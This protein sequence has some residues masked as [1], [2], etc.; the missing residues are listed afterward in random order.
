MATLKKSFVSIEPEVGD[1]ETEVSITVDPNTSLSERTET[2][3]FTATGATK[4]L[5][6]N[7]ERMPFFSNLSLNPEGNFTAAKSGV[8]ATLGQ[9][10]IFIQTDGVAEISH[11]AILTNFPINTQNSVH[12]FWSMFISNTLINNDEQSVYWRFTLDG[13]NWITD[14]GGFQGQ[15]DDYSFFFGSTGSYILPD[16]QDHMLI[17][18]I[19]IGATG[20]EEL[21]QVLIRHYVN[22]MV[23]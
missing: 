2:I 9:T 18:E 17:I 23:S 12:F 13:E 21:Q 7:Q 14:L 19:G 6:V 22:F 8:V 11:M 10:G 1:G 3:N 16:L 20:S 4:S 15:G 5:A